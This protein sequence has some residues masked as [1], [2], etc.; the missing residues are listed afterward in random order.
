MNGKGEIREIDGWMDGC[1]LGSMRWEENIKWIWR[2]EV[3][4][5][6]AKC[7]SCR[8]IL[9]FVTMLVKLCTN[10]HIPNKNTHAPRQYPTDQWSYPCQ[11]SYRTS[12]SNRASRT[13]RPNDV[14]ISIQLPYQIQRNKQ[15]TT[16][17]SDTPFMKGG[18]LWFPHCGAADT[19]GA[20]VGREDWCGSVNRGSAPAGGAGGEFELTLGIGVHLAGRGLS[21]TS[22]ELEEG[23]V[24]E[25]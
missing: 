10:A 5:C 6:N 25:W 1:V 18:L 23:V 19:G 3:R 8:N 7:F 15:N 12:K 24:V 17:T 20:T 4:N 16:R 2:F 21:A 22:V 14:N 11:L 9:K 13:T